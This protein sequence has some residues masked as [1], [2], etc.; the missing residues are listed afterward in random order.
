MER[1]T[2]ILG[3]RIEEVRLSSRLTNSPA[4]LV[5][6]EGGQHA[7]VERLLR[8]QHGGQAR[9]KRIL[10]LNPEHAL[11]QNLSQ[12]HGAAPDSDHLVEWVEVLYDQVLLT[13][14]SPV[15]DPNR[16][17][18]RMTLLLQQASAAEVAAR[19]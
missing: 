16:L 13:E 14:G 17:A 8:A 5:V 12:L 19:S 4:C 15:E 18:R 3:E 11:I 10:E 6:P 7:Y 1:I 9:T 2:E